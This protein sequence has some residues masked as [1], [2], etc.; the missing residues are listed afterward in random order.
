MANQQFDDLDRMYQDFTK[1]DPATGKS[2][3]Q[4]LEDAVKDAEKD[5]KQLTNEISDIEKQIK[6]HQDEMKKMID[7]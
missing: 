5:V 3:K 6:E 1:V 2:K 7:N 4:E